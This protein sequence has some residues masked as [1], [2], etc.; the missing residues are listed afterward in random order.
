MDHVLSLACLQDN[1][2]RDCFSNMC[3][4]DESRGSVLR[5]ERLPIV[6]WKDVGP[7]GLFLVGFR[8]SMYTQ[9]RR[10]VIERVATEVVYLDKNKTWE[11]GAIVRVGY[12]VLLTYAPA[13]NTNTPR[14]SQDRSKKKVR[15]SDT[16]TTRNTF[17]AALWNKQ[18][19]ILSRVNNAKCRVTTCDGVRCT[20]FW[21]DGA[22]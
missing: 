20:R 13:P 9:D 4:C 14:K 5:L 21:K 6:A 22:L 15:C 3:G 17:E 2:D 10:L 19:H 7:L 16:S 11:A 18:K 8:V 1:H 12:R